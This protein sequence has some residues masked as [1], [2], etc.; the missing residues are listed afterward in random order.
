MTVKDDAIVNV[1]EQLGGKGRAILTSSTSTQSSF[2]QEGYELS[3]YTLY[4]VEGIEKGAAD[5]D[6]DG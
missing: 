1:Q 2:E 5:K 6:G 4:L 3:V